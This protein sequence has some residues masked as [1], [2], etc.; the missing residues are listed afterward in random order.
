MAFS[1]SAILFITTRP[2][3]AHHQEVKRE[4][5][6]ESKWKNEKRRREGKFEVR[7]K[8]EFFFISFANLK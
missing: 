6:S 8:S 5:T 1:T 3:L 2:K 4:K 7:E